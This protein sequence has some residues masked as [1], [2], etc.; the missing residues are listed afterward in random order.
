MTT[1]APPALACFLFAG[2]LELELLLL[3]ELEL[4]LL[5]LLEPDLAF[6]PLAFLGL[7]LALRLLFWDLFRSP[8]SFLVL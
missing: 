4:L 5:L 2:E 6:R 7:G 3:L 8:S 1:V